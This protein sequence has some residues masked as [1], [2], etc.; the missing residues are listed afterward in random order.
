MCLAERSC[1]WQEA[2]LP[3]LILEKVPGYMVFHTITG[4]CSVYVPVKPVL[5]LRWHFILSHH[6]A[7]AV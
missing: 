3:I 2:F 4:T 5:L 1:V 7:Q 6:V